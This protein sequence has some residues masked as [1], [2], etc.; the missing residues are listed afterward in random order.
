MIDYEK[1][2]NHLHNLISDTKQLHY[3]MGGESCIGAIQA[4]QV[5]LNWIEENR[6]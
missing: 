6:A 5:I 2:K 4:F 3:A 1:L